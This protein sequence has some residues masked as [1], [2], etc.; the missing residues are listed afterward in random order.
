MR[1]PAVLTV[2][3]RIIGKKAVRNEALAG[4]D[5]EWEESQRYASLKGI[6]AAKKKEIKEVTGRQLRGRRDRRPGQAHEVAAP[7]TRKAG[8]KVGL[9]RGAGAEAQERSEGALMGAVVVLLETADQGIRSTS[10]PAITAARE[11]AK[12]HGGPVVGVVI[13]AGGE[14]GAAATD[15]ARYVD[16]LL[17]LDDAALAAPLA[18]TWAP[19]LAAAVKQ[20]G[21]IGAGRRRPPR[22]ARTCCRGRRPCWARAWPATSPACWAP[23]PS[24]APPTPATPSP[25]S[26]W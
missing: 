3:L 8:L 14:L 24:A 10:L 16:K 22:P 6:M 1:L 7:A 9:G 12:H 5:A 18:E 13:G 17:R 15:A 25:T 19:V 23:R 11:L 4:A 2:D 21:A 26:R 20:A